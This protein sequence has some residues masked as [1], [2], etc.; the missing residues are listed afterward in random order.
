MLLIAPDGSFL[1]V[2][3]AL[4]ALL[5]RD[6]PTLLRSVA[7]M[8]PSGRNIEADLTLVADVIDGKRDTYRLAKRYLRPQR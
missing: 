8:T 4:C 3:P 5:D 2:N 6:E 7:G 1:G